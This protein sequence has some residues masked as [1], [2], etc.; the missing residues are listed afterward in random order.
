M[1]GLPAAQTARVPHAWQGI[2][3]HAEVGPLATPSFGVSSFQFPGRTIL[4][5][6][7]VPDRRLSLLE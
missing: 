7:P 5:S 2:S 6:L 1:S 3:K 4:L